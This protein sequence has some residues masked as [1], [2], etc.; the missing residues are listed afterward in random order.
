MLGDHSAR[1]K[2]TVVP[3]GEQVVDATITLVYLAVSCCI[4]IDTD[5]MIREMVAKVILP[6]TIVTED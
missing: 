6:A 3:A 4:L 2:S 5:A 1:L